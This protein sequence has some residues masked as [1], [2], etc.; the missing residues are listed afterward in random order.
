MRAKHSSHLHVFHRHWYISVLQLR[1][2]WHFRVSEY[3]VYGRCTILAFKHSW[4]CPT[5]WIIMHSDPVDFTHHSL[6]FCYKKNWTYKQGILTCGWRLFQRTK[7]KRI[8]SVATVSIQSHHSV[9]TVSPQCRYSVRI[10]PTLYEHFK[11]SKN[12]SP[13][14]KPEVHYRHFIWVRH[15]RDGTHRRTKNKINTHNW[16]RSMFIC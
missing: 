11:L 7:E 15:R 4:K 5:G 6:T 9:D 16:I 13:Y 2:L 14:T 3:I 12:S 8:Y 10:S 1:V